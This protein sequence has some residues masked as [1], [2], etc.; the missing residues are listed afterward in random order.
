GDGCETPAETIACGDGG[1]RY[2]SRYT[3]V[4]TPKWGHCVTGETECELGETESC[5]GDEEE[6]EYD[7]FMTCE[8]IDGEPRWNGHDCN[9]P[10]VLAFDNEPVALTASVANFDIAGNGCV[11][12]DWPTAATPWLALDRDR[13]GSID[14]GHELFGNGTVMSGG[15]KAKHGFAAL[16][17]L[18][19][20][21]D[22]RVTSADARWSELVLWADHDRDKVSTMWELTPVGEHG[23]TAIELSYWRNPLCDARQN[24]EVER[25][26][27]TYADRSGRSREGSVVDIY[28]AC[29]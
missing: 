29:Q 6:E 24:C 26:S 19:S 7:L 16:S 15:M 2:C 23:V 25:A 27:F 5:F 3:D 14:G 12:T 11:S 1:L 8:V 10:L 21:H 4:W 13:N 17:E 22:G 20:N 9:T 28:L 18:D